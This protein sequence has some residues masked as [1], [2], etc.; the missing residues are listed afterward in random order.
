M[1]C[2]CAKVVN[3]SDISTVYAEA[4]FQNTTH[5]SRSTRSTRS[6]LCADLPNLLLINSISAI[7]EAEHPPKDVENR[8]IL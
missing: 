5:I 3:N 1:L 8:S 2:V 7:A 6:T 4:F